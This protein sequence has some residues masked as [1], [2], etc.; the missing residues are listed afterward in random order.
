MMH[1]HSS[2]CFG[3][4]ETVGANPKSIVVD[5]TP[6]IVPHCLIHSAVR[7]ATYQPK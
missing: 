4:N 7:L 6:C 5:P 2:I 1:V 3:R